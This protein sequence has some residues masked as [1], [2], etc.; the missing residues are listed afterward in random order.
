MKR[1]K[2]SLRIIPICFNLF[3]LSCAADEFPFAAFF[4]RKT[5]TFPPFHSKIIVY[6]HKNFR[7][8]FPVC[9]TSAKGFS[10]KLCQHKEE[11][12]ICL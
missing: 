11:Y 7:V 1:S 4:T 6:L 9:V 5:L 2:L 12:A 3:V 10:R 8:I